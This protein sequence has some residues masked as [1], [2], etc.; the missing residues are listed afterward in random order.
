MKHVILAIS[1]ILLLAPI[2]VF[3]ACSAKGETVAY[4]NG[5]LTSEIDAKNQRRALEKDYNDQYPSNDVTFINA[6][7]PSHLDG[8]GDLIEATSQFMGKPVSAFDFKT[9]LM[10]IYPEVTTRRLLLVGY[11]QGA[12]YANAMYDYLLSHGE[13]RQAVGVY[14]VGAPT[15]YVAGGGAYLNS[16]G[17]MLLND[18]TGNV[19][20]DEAPLPANTRLISSPDDAQ[21]QFPG[22]SFIA[23]YLAGGAGRIVADISSGLAK[24][25]PDLASDKGECFT[26]PDPDANYIAE[27]VG[28]AVADPTAH[29]IGVT[30]GATY[31]AASFAIGGAISFLTHTYAAATSGLSSAAHTV[32]NSPDNPAAPQ[33]QVKNLAVIK[34]LYGSSL[35]E[36][37]YEELNGTV[38]QGAA[39]AAAVL[40]TPTPAPVPAPTSTVATTSVRVAPPPTIPRTGPLPLGEGSGS[41]IASP[42]GASSTSP[43]D[44][45][46]LPSQGADSTPAPAAPFDASSTAPVLS[47]AACAQSL[48]PDFC[49]APRTT[50]AL[51]W[52]GSAGA[53]SYNIFVNG[54][55]AQTVAGTSS[56]VTLADQ[57]S[58]SIAV[59]AVD[60][61]GTSLA[62]APQT[63]YVFAHPVVINEIAWAGTEN[64]P[65]DQWLE[66]KNR[67]PYAIDLSHMAVVATEGGSQYIP[68]SGVIWPL[69]DNGFYVIERA[70]KVITDLYEHGHIIY[71]EPLSTTGE[72]LSLQY[73]DG[74]ATT[75]LDQTP[76]IA[77]CGKWCAGSQSTPIGFATTG[78]VEL[79]TISMSRI[80]AVASGTLASNWVND[81]AYPTVTPFTDR[82]NR[83]RIIGTPNAENDTIAADAG[84][85]CYPDTAPIV[86]GSAYHPQ[87]SMCTYLSRF[88]MQDER[89]MGALYEGV[90]GSSTL[91]N[92][93]FDY[94]QLRGP[95]HI[96]QNQTIPADTPA[97]TPFFVAIWEVQVEPYYN[98][99]RS[100]E[101]FNS[102]WQTGSQ[103]TCHD[104]GVCTDGGGA[105]SPPHDN[106]RVI[107][108]T[109]VP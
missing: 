102:Y 75:T 58:S 4:I 92:M 20:A 12:F 89:R 103:Q 28:F 88:V 81:G 67:T 96:A 106:Y 39:V 69:P 18:L 27:G 63:V 53:V 13:P 36:E 1:G 86:P 7:N 80:D 31:A 83:Y 68:L 19:P 11:S 85:Y 57:A 26:E 43:P 49:F 44:S 76:P 108:F 99:P 105:A 23:S 16:S 2:N 109:Y 56:S 62:S 30:A 100:I 17:D 55:L 101:N 87:S 51:S 35:D 52:S 74:A 84:F 33:N 61:A 10:Q 42:A 64:Y 79:N 41:A 47:I 48:S 14:E 94:S 24:L 5:I 37:T 29:V 98:P 21:A 77:T 66:L 45:G 104:N 25:T 15:H 107:P 46:S 70:Q 38:H 59:A 97:G 90:V 40:P 72:Q 34:K 93:A 8:L 71:F 82:D 73:F 91:I 3:A 22:H 54:V 78:R 32:A 6:Y 50:I 95:V 65:D 9:M 60:V